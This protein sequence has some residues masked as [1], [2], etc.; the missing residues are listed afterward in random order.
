MTVDVPTSAPPTDTA[1]F[2]MLWDT[3]PFTVDEDTF[4]V[5]PLLSAKS[6]LRAVRLSNDAAESEDDEATLKIVEQFMRIV[7]VPESVD[8]FV[9]RLLVEDDDANVRPISIMQVNQI[10]PWALGVAGG[11]PTTSSSS[12]APGSSDLEPGT[13]STAS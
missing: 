11:R 3:H 12:S 4:F 8:R 2:S 10:M 5:R 9:T 7:L 1:D 13:S 6:M